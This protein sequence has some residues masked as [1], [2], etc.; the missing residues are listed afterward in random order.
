MRKVCFAGRRLSVLACVV[1]RGDSEREGAVCAASMPRST[2]L[3]MADAGSR[4]QTLHDTHRRAV[5]GS[6]LFPRLSWASLPALSGVHEHVAVSGN[7][8]LCESVKQWND[9][10]IF[11]TWRKAVSGRYAAA[12]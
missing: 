7:A 1:S 6:G 4:W 3:R 9:G 2:S 12:K 11:H 5:C 8:I 10:M